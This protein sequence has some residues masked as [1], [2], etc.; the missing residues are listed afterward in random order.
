M[1]TLPMWMLL[2][3]L[4]I[5]ADGLNFDT[6]GI[7]IMQI[8]E[9]RDQEFAKTMTSTERCARLQA[10]MEALNRKAGWTVR[11][12]RATET[13]V[14]REQRENAMLRM[15]PTIYYLGIERHH[16]FADAPELRGRRQ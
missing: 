15:Y 6:D 1:I 9:R 8:C 10:E 5:G 12:Q 3:G 4:Q 7:A 2:I 13:D 16:E 11:K 14:Q